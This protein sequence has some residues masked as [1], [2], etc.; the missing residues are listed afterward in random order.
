MTEFYTV[1]RIDNTR[2]VRAAAPRRLK[3]CGKLVAMGAALA[4]VAMFYSW[5]HFQYIQ[6]S[7]QV[8]QL[9]ADRAHAFE[10]NQELKLDVSSLT[11][12][13]RIAGIARNELGMTATVP[14][15][16]APAQSQSDAA[17]VA[18]VRRVQ[19]PPAR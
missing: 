6:L 13:T 5:Q 12:P 17:V 16:S 14:G 18:Q 7:Y 8:E 9:K 15:Q 19:L 4:L 2:V 3:E 10:L 1:K 11:S